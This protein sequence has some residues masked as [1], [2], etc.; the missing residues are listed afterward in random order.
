MSATALEAAEQPVPTRPENRRYQRVRVNLLGRFM[1][2]S[3]NEY[4]CQVIDMSPGGAAVMTPIVGEIGERVIAYVD[5]VGRI[6]GEITRYIDG[7]F[8]MSIGATHRK[9]ERLA[10]QL[11][12]LANQNE[13]ELAEDRRHERITPRRAYSHIVLPDGRE[14]Q[15]RVLDVSLSGAAIAMEARPELGTT[16][17]L[18]KMRARVV[19]HFDD[20]VGVEF[21]A[22]QALDTIQDDL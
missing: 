2:A 20:G 21:T 6:E 8:A 10:N 7:G 16:L 19:R 3:R 15:C 4:P 11:T 9:R 17:T 13:L 1:L 18:G 14:M 22:I 12:W 5:H